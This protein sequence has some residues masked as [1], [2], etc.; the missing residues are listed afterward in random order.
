VLT[1]FVG[2]MAGVSAVVLTAWRLAYLL[3]V[4]R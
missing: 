2:V 4:R 3:L 1:V